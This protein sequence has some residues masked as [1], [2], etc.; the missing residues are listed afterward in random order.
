MCVSGW[1]QERGRQSE[2]EESLQSRYRITRIGPGALGFHGSESTVRRAGGVVVLRRPGVYGTYRRNL[3]VSMA[4]RGQTVEVLSGEKENAVML[5]AGTR[6]Y[7]VA[8]SAASD[9]ITLGL[10]S[11]SDISSGGQNAPV[12]AS[13]NF[14]FDK[15]TLARGET[16]KI[17]PELDW[18][19]LPEGT[20]GEAAAPAPAQVP[21]TAPTVTAVPVTGKA[22][23]LRP[24]MSRDEIVAALGRPNR[25]I[26]FSARRWMEYRGL[27]AVLNQ[28]KLDF[29]DAYSPP[30]ATAKVSSEPAGAEVFLDGSFAGTTPSSLQVAPGSHKIIIK[31]NGF[32]DWQRDLTVTAGSEVSVDAKLEK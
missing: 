3:M 29:V 11:T 20:A 4:I 6:F 25:E 26:I 9:S 30:A 28:A 21:A 23:D 8:V 14:F 16:E 15:D 27:V 5:V 24:G 22:I 13:L 18:W 7:V 2:I 12:W 1:A 17:Y 31:L 32:Q 10:L 19:L